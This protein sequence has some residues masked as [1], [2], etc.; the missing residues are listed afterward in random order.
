MCVNSL[1][2][3]SLLHAQQFQEQQQQKQR[4]QQCS[5]VL[6]ESSMFATPSIAPGMSIA[7]AGVSVPA[8]YCAATGAAVGG[9]GIH[10]F[11]CFGLPS[12]LMVPT[13]LQQQQQ[14][15]S[16]PLQGFAA[17]GHPKNGSLVTGVPAMTTSAGLQLQ[18]PQQQQQ[19][20]QQQ[21][22]FSNTAGMSANM[23]SYE[24][25]QQ[26]QQQH[27]A[28]QTAASGAGVPDTA[29]RL[30]RNSSTATT[31]SAKAAAGGCAKRKGPST[32]FR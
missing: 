6:Q 31:A 21:Q 19:Q 15:Q 20:Q 2:P 16:Y 23:G 14:Q 24:Q 30:R 3:T 12:V 18:Q 8:A 28:I 1:P 10:T 22:G 13:S 32:R 17:T 27:E 4:V 5:G 29:C 26:Q 9:Y 7:G 11:E 25:Q